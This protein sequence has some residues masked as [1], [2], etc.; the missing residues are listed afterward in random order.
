MKNNNKIFFNIKE[1]A[2]II[3]TTPATIRNWEKKK[4]FIAKRNT[5]NYRIYSFDDIE[6]LK[7]IKHYSKEEGLNAVS[8]KKIIDTKVISNA[9]F[10]DELTEKEPKASEHKH[11]F[12]N[13][14]KEFRKKRGMTLK[15]VSEKT[16]ISISHISRIENGDANTS[17]KIL[18]VLGNFYGQ[19]VLFFYGDNTKEK[20]SK[21]KI[22]KDER[23]VVDVKLPG[24]KIEMLSDGL[25]KMM[26]P[27]VFNVEPHSGAAETHAHDG[28]EFIFILKGT[29]SV[30]LDNE[31]VF[32]LTEGESMYFNSSRL[33][34]WENSSSEYTQL[35]WVHSRVALDI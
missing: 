26:S 23:E 10:I 14:W 18:N 12:T 7:E 11:P 15:D 1:V 5:N 13:K 30:T 31:E 2:Q 4:I 17:L 21:T 22:T 20:E 33:H 27:A 34:Y 28:E 3:K 9:N 16:G 32:E 35:I 24:V 25:N 29:L 19:S 6:I 8:I